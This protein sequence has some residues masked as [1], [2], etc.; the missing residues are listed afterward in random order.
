MDCSICT[1]LTVETCQSLFNVKE[2]GLISVDQLD[3]IDVKLIAYRTGLEED[4]IQTICYHHKQTLLTD[5]EWLEKRCCNPFKNHKKHIKSGLKPISLKMADKAKA[6]LALI[7]GK[8]LCPN[9]RIQIHKLFPDDEEPRHVS[10]EEIQ[11]LEA[12]TSEE[13]EKSSNN[14]EPRRISDEEMKELDTSTSAEIEKRNINEC[15]SAIGISPLKTKGLHSS[16]KATLGKRKFFSAMQC[17]K[18]K[19]AKSLN[20][21]SELL[22]N[23]ALKIKKD[24]LDKA[25]CFD[26][27]IEHL[28]AKVKTV[29]STKIKIQIL[30]LAPTD[31]SYKK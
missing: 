26:T 18:T 3:T 30:T 27:M 15:F 23:E 13:S 28:V 9:C 8:K 4:K 14:E 16:G 29:E 7:P 12:G 21:D 5:Y 25:K 1:Q 31:W 22:N 24:I 10:D 6:K 20:V 19:V 17:V 11:E 2:V